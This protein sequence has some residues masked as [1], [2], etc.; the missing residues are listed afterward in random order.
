MASSTLP[1]PSKAAD[2]DRP[3][4]AKPRAGETVIVH[5]RSGEAVAFDFDIAKAKIVVR[6]VD[7]HL[8]FDDGALIVMPGLGVEMATATPPKLYFGDDYVSPENFF[9]RIGPVELATDYSPETLQTTAATGTN[10]EDGQGEAQAMAPSKSAPGVSA[11]SSQAG[12]PEGAASDGQGGRPYQ[13]TAASVEFQPTRV[14]P[15]LI[16]SSGVGPGGGGESDGTGNGQYNDP[17]FTGIALKDVGIKLY[18]YD[19]SVVTEQTS[20]FGQTTRTTVTGFSS[21]AAAPPPPG[22][23]IGAGARLAALT[24]PDTIH[25]SGIPDILYADD[26]LAGIGRVIAKPRLSL[27]LT[28]NTATKGT[29]EITLPEGYTLTEDSGFTLKGGSWT[30]AV[31]DAGAVLQF[32]LKLAYAVPTDA[33]LKNADGFYGASATDTNLSVA[34][35]VFRSKVNGRTTGAYTGTFELGVRDTSTDAGLTYLHDNKPVLVLPAT[36]GGNLIDAS[37]GDDTVV[38]G[39]AGDTI[40]GGDGSDVVAYTM[41]SSG[42]SVA[43][44]NG[45][46]AAVVGTTGYAKGDVIRNVENLIGSNFAD[47]LTGNDGPNSLSGGGPG[48]TGNDLLRGGRGDDTLSGGGGA[49]TLEGGEGDDVYIV[50]SQDVVVENAGEGHDRVLARDAGAFTLSGSVED[51]ENIGSTPL[52]AHGSAGDN[53]MLGNEQAET[54]I[55]GG[56]HDTLDGRA[57]N[58]SLVGGDLADSIAGGDGANTLAGGGGDDNYLVTSGLDVIVEG[59][60]GGNDTVTVNGPS[61]YAMGAQVET[62]LSVGTG[63]F[64]GLGNAQDNLISANQDPSLILRNTLAGGDGAD[65]LV[66][67]AGADWL[68]GDEG[69]DL[70]TGGNGDNTLDGGA[71]ADTLVGGVGND[72]YRIDDAGDVIA[73]EA[74]GVDTIEIGRA[75][76]SGLHGEGGSGLAITVGSGFEN[77]RYLGSSA[78]T[79]TGNDADNLVAGGS[80]DDSLMGGVGSDTLEGGAGADTLEGGP[81]AD[82]LRGGAGADVYVMNAAGDVV[83]GETA[84]DVNTVVLRYDPVATVRLDQFGAGLRRLVYEGTVSF[85]GQ[86]D[87]SQTLSQ[88]LVGG[89]QADALTGGLGND[90]LAGQGTDDSLASADTLDGGAG[91]DTMAGGAGNDVYVVDTAGD[92]IVEDSGVGSGR[93]TVRTS[94]SAYA[95]GQAGNANVENLVSSGGGSFTGTGTSADNVVQ[96]GAGPNLLSG[97][98]GDDTLVG[99]G[100]ADTLDGGTGA[101]S[102]VGGAGGD[103][104]LVSDVRAQI[105]EVLDPSGG[106]DTVILNPAGLV[107]AGGPAPLAFALQDGLEILR[108]AGTQSATLSGNAGANTIVSG[109]GDDSLFGGAGADSLSAGAGADTLDGGGAADTLEGGAGGDVYLVDDATTV[110]VEGSGAGSGTDTIRTMLSAYALG[111]ARNANVENLTF[112]GTGAF[113]GVGSASANVITGADTGN[114]LD[115]GAGADTLVGG[116]GNDVY[117]VDN[118]GDIIVDTGGTNDGVVI[119]SAGQAG[120]FFTTNGAPA[121]VAYQL[122]GGLETLAYR[123]TSQATLTGNEA[124]N[125]ITGGSGANCLSGGGGADTL[126]G[127]ASG[128]TILGGAGSDSIDAG[129]GANLVYGSVPPSDPSFATATEGDR[130]QAGSGADTLIGSAGADTILTG[131]GANSVDAGGGADTIL[132]GSGNDTLVAGS[133][134]DTVDAGS[135]NNAIDGGV[136]SDFVT[137]LGGADTILGGGGANTVSAGDGRNLVD[138]RVSGSD[139]TAMGDS[140][141]T[142]LDSDTIYGSA[143]LDTILAGAG[144]NSIDAGAGADTIL[145]GVN[146]DTV[147]GGSGDDTI[148]AGAGNNSIDGGVGNDLVTALGGADTILGGGGANTV[149][150]GDGRNLVDMRVSGSDPLATGDSLVTGQDADTIFGSAGNDSILAGAGANSIDAGAGADSILAGV[151]GDTILGGSGAD[152]ID[153]GEGANLVYASILPSDPAFA[154]AR[155]GDL[156]R[157]GAGADTL[158]GSAG[159][160]TIDAGAG[161]NLIDARDNGSDPTATGD[162]LVAGLDADTILGSGGRDTILAGAGA[163]SIDAGSGA[164][165]IVAGAD[166]DTIFGGAGADTIDAGGGR[167]L[168]YASLRPTDAGYAWATAGDSISAGAD[169]DTIIGS[170]GNDTII[171]GGGANSVDGGAGDDSLVG[172]IGSDTILGGDG[173][174]TLV[175]GGVDLTSPVETLS[176][177]NGDDVYVIDFGQQSY[178]TIADTAGND[179]IRTQLRTYT[180]AQNNGNSVE[181]LTF[182]YSDTASGAS[183][184]GN[185]LANVITGA[186]GADTLQAAANTDTTVGDTLIAGAGNDS[187][188]AAAGAG[189]RLDGGSDDDSLQGNSGA[190][191]LIGGQGNDLLLGGAGS[192]SLDGGVGAN[193]L[194]GGQGADRIVAGDGANLVLGGSSPADDDLVAASAADTITLGDGANTVFGGAGGDVITVGNG[195]SSIDAGADADRVTLGM[196]ANTAFGG[197][198]NDTIVAASGSSA[199]NVLYG[200]TADAGDADA[201]GADSLLGGGGADTLFGGAGADTL[202]GG[203]GADQLY[204]GT[205]NDVLIL[206]ASATGEGGANDDTFRLLSGNVSVVGGAGTD[207]ITIDGSDATTPR[208]FTLAG[209]TS[210]IERLTVVGTSNDVRPGFT[211]AGDGAANTVTGGFGDDSLAG[212]GGSD[213]LDGG[214]GNDTLDGTG[215]A[216]TLAG[217]L[218][219]D[220]YIVDDPAGIDLIIEAGGSADE[221]RTALASYQLGDVT[222]TSGIEA[223]RYTGSGNFTGVGDAG[224]QTFFGGAGNDSIVGAGGAN[225]FAINATLAPSDYAG[226]VLNGD[227]TY[228]LTAGTFGNLTVSS[229]RTTFTLGYAGNTFGTDVVSQI[230]VVRFNNV[231][232]RLTQGGRYFGDQADASISPSGPLGATTRNDVLGDAVAGT[233]TILADEMFGGQGNDTYIL[234]NYDDAVFENA[235]GGT[236]TVIVTQA[237][238]DDARFATTQVN[239]GNLNPGTISLTSNVN[240]FYDYGSAG[241]PVGAANGGLN[242]ENLVFTG[243]SSVILVGNTS[244]NSLLGSSGTDTLD[245]GAGNDTLDGGGGTDSFIGGAGDDVFIVDSASESVSEAGAGGSDSLWV[246]NAGLYDLSS[247]GFVNVENIFVRTASSTSVGGSF[248]LVGSS[249][250]NTL[251]GSIGT[252]DSIVGNAGADVL[253]SL[254]AGDTLDGGTGSDSYVVTMAAGAGA[255]LIRE[256]GGDGADEVRTTLS[257]FDLT[258]TRY[259]DVAAIEMLRA[260]NG[261]YGDWFSPAAGAFTGVGNAQLNTIIGGSANDSLVGL[262]N[263]DSLVGGAGDDTLD[264]ATGDSFSNFSAYAD[265]LSGGAGND[266]YIVNTTADVVSGEAAGSGAGFIDTIQVANSGLFNISAGGGAAANA[267]TLAAGS[268]V[269]NLVYL[270]GSNFTLAGNALGNSIVGGSGN[271]SLIGGNST[272]AATSSDADSMAGGLG[273]DTYFVDSALDQVIENAGEGTDLVRVTVGAYALAANVENMIY[274]GANTVAGT[275][276]SLVGNNLANQIT[277]FGGDDTL[278]GGVNV[279][280]PDGLGGFSTPGDTQNGGFG[281]DIYILRNAN[282]LVTGENATSGTDTAVVRYD[283][284]GALIYIGG[285]GRIS[286]FVEN[287]VYEGPGAATVIGSFTAAGFNGANSIVG[288]AGDDVLAGGLSGSALNTG[289]D[290]LRGGAGND[291]YFID[292]AGDSVVGEVSGGGAD[293]IFA[294]T[295]VDLSIA[296][297]AQIEML[298]S[299]GLSNSPAA[300][301]TTS[302]NTAFTGIG[303]ALDNTII[304][305]LNNVFNSLAGGLGN[306]S[307]VA[308]AATATLDGGQGNDTLDA[309]R[310]TV[311]A[312][313]S[314][315]GGAGNDS[316]LGSLGAETLDG[317]TGADTMS[318]GNGN[319]VYIVD[320]VQDRVIE[321]GGASGGVDEIRLSGSIN[322]FSL[323]DT[324]YGANVGQ[325][326]N[327]RGGGGDS[328]ATGTNY[329]LIGNNANNLIVG[330]GGADSIVG[331]YGADT[332]VGAAGNDTLSAAPEANGFGFT[333]GFNYYNAGAASLSGGATVDLATGF[334]FSYTDRVNTTTSGE[335][336]TLGTSMNATTDTT[337]GRVTPRLLGNTFYYGWLNDKIVVNMMNPYDMVDVN[338]NLFNNGVQLTNVFTANVARDYLTHQISLSYDSVQGLVLT[339]DGVRRNWDTTGTIGSQSSLVSTLSMGVGGPQPLMDDVRLTVSGVTLANYSFESGY[340]NSGSGFGTLTNQDVY[341][342]RADWMPQTPAGSSLSG[343]AGN[344][345]LVGSSAADTLDGGTGADTMSGGA[346]NDLF[347]VDSS[348]DVVIEAASGG[349]D[350]VLV[351][352]VAGYTLTNSNIETLSVDTRNGAYNSN[353]SLTVS[354]TTAALIVG[355]FGSDTLIGGSGADTLYGDSQI[356]T[357]NAFVGGTVSGGY[358][359]SLMGG[360]GD[361]DYYADARDRIYD[362]GTSTGDFA[363]VFTDGSVG[364][365][366]LGGNSSQNYF[367]IEH[368]TI[369]TADT[370]VG[371]SISMFNASDTT[372]HILA[373]GLGADTIT[374]SA[375]ADTLFGDTSLQNQTGTS[376]DSMDGR[377]GNDRYYM[378]FWGSGDAR[379]DRVN[380]SGTVNSS[381]DW[382][383]VSFN[384]GSNEFRLDRDATGIE[385]VDISGGAGTVTGNAGNNSFSDGG[386]ND[387]IFGGDGNDVFTFTG[388]GGR[389]TIDGGNGNDSFFIDAWVSYL[390]I[391]A[392]TTPG[393]SG[394]TINGGAGN[395]T[396][397]F[398]DHN[399]FG[400]QGSALDRLMDNIEQISFRGAGLSGGTAARPITFAAQD[401]QGI[402]GAGTAS[403]LTVRY[404]TTGPNIDYIAFTTPTGG[405]ITNGSGQTYTSGVA[406]AGT[407]TFKDAV[408]AT[409]AT[410]VLQ[411]S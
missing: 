53:L 201:S 158:V 197:L 218:G 101:D 38:A 221:V 225:T 406:A 298:V 237:F 87:P 147:L 36:L 382:V 304:G 403:S 387:S 29:L 161:R 184:V 320:T 281:N 371:V 45:S 249:A 375:G 31:T 193:T 312:A 324:T 233:G 82:V 181:N 30:R 25:G 146:N 16:G 39:A 216:A 54:Y 336:F 222:A 74:G 83:E 368:L 100:A 26:P 106:V 177:G 57:G 309:S 380:D 163:N 364:S 50:T 333:N 314:L 165:S 282:D 137:A 209:A 355:G 408:G 180:L 308:G 103:V 275:G 85:T 389:D 283:P 357:Q 280:L 362:S 289:E 252:A 365:F 360:A 20:G 115:G 105:A 59:S 93:D 410:L 376:S 236:D 374:G 75:G 315:S 182:V 142:G 343:G 402:V 102:L 136:G 55:G 117:V 256:T 316:L 245:G 330:A 198:G 347:L 151:D 386:G 367:G 305:S 124:A 205:G 310:G 302:G 247:A 159:I 157:A 267:F 179:T 185:V 388:G 44:G 273:N 210:G 277:T 401:I 90:S 13:I 329:T 369:V 76:L 134:D 292:S 34:T 86:G 202:D 212:G 194:I 121:A 328:L 174:D 395:D 24:A 384:G 271:D 80:N 112:T 351:S 311:N 144:A 331:F 1:D 317:G 114:T 392:A 95:L 120:G 148:D 359:D 266:R 264:G 394:D 141:V 306:D 323:S 261:T 169:A 253:V 353:I 129:E 227:G 79:L 154:N 288:G 220:V 358:A 219:N 381:A 286:Q 164:D 155:A 68:R 37:G 399:G 262:S 186:G 274:L 6:G 229:T 349:T 48:D 226:L 160:D 200:G 231:S 91:A 69:D 81:G 390:F 335:Y 232:F 352:G 173:A 123:G 258:D 278:D 127:A 230:Q 213:R 356:A 166:A 187:L 175:S 109:T 321:T 119:G 99:G 397:S 149:S 107:D 269:E 21:A 295:A 257:S 400:Q 71:G 214:A 167:N 350:T 113:S 125:L 327:L 287:L 178:V 92:V 348:G 199:G 139:P 391:P 207:E 23:G 344:D 240:N 11:P 104:Y 176:G 303:N 128:D 116:A 204:G 398:W 285:T 361:D 41:S 265:I 272:S 118:A 17:P 396:V 96:G 47:T 73:P 150:A 345:S 234:N 337:A 319:D 140:L 378:A 276:A 190:D 28:G 49:N 14:Q 208:S 132:A 340:G 61:A 94:L 342:V 89:A 246:R 377:E 228:N 404:D 206:R 51:L 171:T 62:M 334:T 393:T 67:A 110:I 111:Q 126:F 248:T 131:A 322:V 250:A 235:G 32:D 370:S 383:S 239:N 4:V 243:T 259:G 332:L 307:L 152:T 63:A 260:V 405:S 60:G 191:T 33:A 270:G 294:A 313:N 223:V 211:L 363:S 341:F 254:A 122:A 192:D 133:G 70:L 339:I 268:N 145:A 379:N 5:A 9:A 42:V 84:A 170:A 156:L 43:L 52:L 346:G 18:G 77:L 290:T 409:L 189:D 195:A 153:A 19:A 299:A 15:L 297:Y 293:T 318:G 162:S 40:D 373:G 407:Y 98:A 325:I 215:S 143:G 385:A 22:S 301:F 3:R 224:D 66:G 46:T 135:G 242:I 238:A 108:Y 10:P 130:L 372:P 411:A 296:D 217:G 251:V 300:A 7:I 138:M 291:A 338:G 35:V 188:L 56:G 255:P 78:V 88:T 183:G 72:V 279:A 2:A 97:L 168:I 172:G 366:V 263:V 64:S 203:G 8:V 196:G 244:A 326:E 65:T 241:A 27:E 354:Q 284:A 12:S 58:D